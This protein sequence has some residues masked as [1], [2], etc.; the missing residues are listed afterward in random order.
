MKITIGVDETE[1]RWALVND[2]YDSEEV[3]G[4]MDGAR[5]GQPHDV[6]RVMSAIGLMPNVAFTVEDV[7]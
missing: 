2:N 4:I 5:S 3:D 7:S 6:G 1:A